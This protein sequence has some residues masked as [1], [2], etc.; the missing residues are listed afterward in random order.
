MTTA[1]RPRPLRLLAALGRVRVRDVRGG[2]RRGVACRPAVEPVLP[3]QIPTRG[4]WRT[5]FPLGLFA[6]LLGVAALTFGAAAGPAGAHDGDAVI[7]IEAV[8]PAGQSIH[9]IV[10][11][12]WANDGHPATDATVTAT[13]I[14]PDGTQLTPVPLAPADEDGRYSGP[15]EYP[16]PG[17]WTV[18][19]TAI[20][21]T[22]TIEQAQEVTATAP[23]EAPNVTTGESTDGGF[24]PADD[25]TGAS[26]EGDTTDADATAAAADSSDSGGSDFPVLLVVAAGAVVL[27]GAVTAVNVIRRTRANP[28]AGDEPDGDPPAAD[29][30]G[31]G[32]TESA[33]AG[34]PSESTSAD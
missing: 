16:A 5:P 2:R 29:P 1:V 26:A 19:I 9:Y 27:V 17:A 4:L 21:P 23:T 3:R 28:P 10:R 7:A 32:S 13:G 30:P 34:A 11:V 25:G 20:E 12:T 31:D 18:R 6:G 8:H 33:A 24:A 14:A 22:G 15:V